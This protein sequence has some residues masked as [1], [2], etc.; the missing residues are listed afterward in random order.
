ML[1]FTLISTLNQANIFQLKL[2]LPQ[3]SV[4]NF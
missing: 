4:T 1:K 3:L 2:Y